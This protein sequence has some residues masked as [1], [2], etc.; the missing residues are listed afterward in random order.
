MHPSRVLF[1]DISM[2][3]TDGLTFVRAIRTVLDGGTYVSS[4]IAM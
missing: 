4:A 2:P 3:G 1:A